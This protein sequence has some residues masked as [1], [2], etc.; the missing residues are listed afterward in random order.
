MTV[1]NG[2]D[3]NVIDYLKSGWHV[4]VHGYLKATAFISEKNGNKDLSQRF[5]KIGLCGKVSLANEELIDIM[6]LG[7]ILGKHKDQEML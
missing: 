6:E 5:E 2:L 1:W 7:R 4:E 3:E